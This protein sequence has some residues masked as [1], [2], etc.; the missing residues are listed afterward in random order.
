[1][2]RELLRCYF[3]FIFYNIYQ[4]PLVISNSHR[5]RKTC[6]VQLLLKK[7]SAGKKAQ[8]ASYFVEEYIAPEKSHT[9]DENLIM[10]TC[11]IIVSQMV[12]GSC[13]KGN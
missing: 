13:S 1:M 5:N 6:K 10:P 2:V 4:V 11:K 8:E 12:G 3:L 7:V 9:V